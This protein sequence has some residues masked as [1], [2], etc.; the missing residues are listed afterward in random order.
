ML[1]ELLKARSKKTIVEAATM[2]AEDSGLFDGLL[3]TML[4]SNSKAA[5]TAAW[6]MS[7]AVD[8]SGSLPPHILPGLIRLLMHQ[9]NSDGVKRN[10]T[11]IFQCINIPESCR[12][13]IADICMNCLVSKNE[14]VAVKAYS[15]TVLQS[16]IKYIPEIKEEVV[17]E[18][19]RQMPYS[20]PAFT[21]R[22]KAFLKAMEK[23]R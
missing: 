6:I 23:S 9:K 21:V 3:K 22:G 18:V 14:T 15:I 8:I 5:S 11:K 7:D 12:W 13:D 1:I 19:E 20:S 10:I 2:V 17:F 16:L 4:E